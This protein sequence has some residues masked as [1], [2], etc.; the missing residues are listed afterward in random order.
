M[1][2]WLHKDALVSRLDALISEEAD[3][4]A[5]LTHE[6]RQKAEAEVLSD[7][8]ANERDE[9]ALTWQAQ[10]QG[11]PIEHRA[12]ISPLAILQCRLI[13]TPHAVPS[14]GSSTEHA[15]DIM[16]AGRR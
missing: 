13:T 6:A 12:D 2:C 5:A 3:D 4:K 8:V 11:L 7:I 15:Y 1:T 16:L 9:A 10:A 14:S